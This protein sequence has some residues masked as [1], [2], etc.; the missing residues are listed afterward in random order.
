ML[1]CGSSGDSRNK[2]ILENI[3]DYIHQSYL[4][5]LSSF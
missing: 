5:S 2:G 1:H 3:I 4:E